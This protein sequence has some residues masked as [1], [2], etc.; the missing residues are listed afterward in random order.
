MTSWGGGS[1]VE[2]ILLFLLSVEVG[3]REE[4]GFYSL[5][6]GDSVLFCVGVEIVGGDCRAV[7]YGGVELVSGISFFSWC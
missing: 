7:C 6:G 1:V 4:Q 2:T 3:W 5:R